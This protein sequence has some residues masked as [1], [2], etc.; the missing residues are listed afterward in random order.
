M[1]FTSGRQKNKMK[2]Q[3]HCHIIDSAESHVIGDKREES[4]F[5]NGQI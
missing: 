4:L 1:Y 2:K 5:Y 3:H